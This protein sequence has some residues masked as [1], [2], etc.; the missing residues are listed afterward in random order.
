MG[1]MTARRVLAAAV[2]VGLASPAAASPGNGIRFGGSAGRLHPFLELETRYD[3][4]VSYLAT[5]ERVGDLVLMVRPGFELAAPGELTAVQLRAA[6]SWAQYLGLQ[7]DT[8]DLSRLYGEAS[9][10]FGLNRRGAVGLELT[11]NFR[12]SAS[13]QALNIGAALISNTNELRLAVPWRPGGGALLVT[14]SGEW[15]LETFEPYLEG[16]LCLADTPACDPDRVADLGYNELRGGLEVSWKFL[17]RTALVLEGSYFTRVP[18]ADTG[19]ADGSGARVWTGVT[20]LFSA[21]IA[22]TIKGGY[23]DTLGSLGEAYRTWLANAEVEWLPLETARVKAG[24]VHD[25][26]LDPGQSTLF[27]ES[28][29]F[30][31]HR[32]YAEGRVLMAGRYTFRLTGQY[33]RRTYELVSSTS[34]DLIR[35]EPSVEVELARWLRAGIGYAFT[36]RTTELPAAALTGTG[37]TLPGYDYDKSEGWLRLSA[38]Y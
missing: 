23:G 4:N 2:A 24:Y 27:G 16:P 8:S 35:G 14:T 30:S 28:A 26:G 17:P 36:R 33:E 6:L 15:R 32:L 18:N 7:G 34:A 25:Y 13:L 29:L 22:G 19:G 10:G 9:L 38:T 21:R 31:S 1:V 5:G 3:S 11:D 20:G 12:R 37:T